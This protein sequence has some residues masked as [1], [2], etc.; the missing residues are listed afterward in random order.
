MQ[1][2]ILFGLL[3]LGMIITTPTL[4]DAATEPA[5]VS[6]ATNLPR[7]VRQAVRAD[8]RNRTGRVGFRVASFSAESWPD[9]CLGLARP[10]QV[11]TQAIV[12]GWRVVMT[13]GQNIWVYRTNSSGNVL[14]LESQ[15][16]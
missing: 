8:L 4:A 9:G 2:Q 12:P 6:Q 10:G 5:L 14:R 3:V 15:P 7:P 16:G 13:D 1:R 11:C